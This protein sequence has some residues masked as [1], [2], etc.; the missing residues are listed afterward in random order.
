MRIGVN[1]GHTVSG[2]IGSGA[3]GYL[4]E[5]DETRK[6]GSILIDLLIRRGHTVY[7]C[8][9]DYAK[10]V[11]ADLDA[12]CNFANAQPLDMFISL[13]FN[14]SNGKGNGVEVYTYGGVDKACAKSIVDAI[15]NLGFINRGIKDGAHLA[16]INGTIAP[17]VLI[18]I[19]FCDNA[20]D[21]N[22][23]KHLGVY[24]I[25][26]TIC[27]AICGSDNKFVTPKE[28]T[29]EMKNYITIY[30]E[31][32]FERALEKAKNENSPLYWGFYKLVNK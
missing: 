23:Y 9:N 30:D 15:A 13:H 24:K 32:G 17:A 4:N 7:N 14:A 27:D 8:T 25:A 5:S 2:T 31:V 29:N 28:I 26:E 12:I 1:C 20:N 22:R 11:Q 6:V 18:E 21:S 16:V 19:C 3:V 10:S